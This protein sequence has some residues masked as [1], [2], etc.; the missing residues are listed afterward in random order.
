MLLGREPE[1]L[2]LDRLLADAREGRSGVLA[3]VGEAGIGKTALLDYAA[4]RAEGMLVLRARGVEPEAEIPFAGLAELLRPALPALDAIPPPQAAALAGALALAPPSAQDRFAVGAA[5]LS[6]VSAC[7]EQQPLL[8]LVDDA[9]LLDGSSAEALLFAA[10]RLLADPIALVLSVRE[11]ERSLV[12]GSDLRTLRLGGLARAEASQLLAALDVKGNVVDRLY[13][14]TAG[15]PLALIEL[16]SEADRVAELPAGGPVPISTSISAAFLRRYRQLSEATRR[17]LLLVAAGT[18]DDIAV[19]AR[20]AAAL[21]LELAGLDEAVE[22]ELVSVGGGRVEFRHPLARSAVYADAGAAERRDAHTALAAALPDRDV[23]RRAWHLAAAS[24]GPNAEAAAALAAAGARA[25][26]RSAYAAA[27]SVYEHA[28]RLCPAEDERARLVVAAAE[29]AWLAGD[30]DRTLRLLDE[31]S[32]PA[33]TYLRGQVAMSRGPVEE[34]YRL[35]V[36]AAEQADDSEEA[37]VRYAHAV[38]ACFYSGDAAAMKSAVQ[39]AVELAQEGASARATFLSQMALAVASVASGDGHAGIAAARRA[40]EILERSDE[41]NDDPWLLGWAALGPLWLREA[42]T[43]RNLLDRAFEEARTR[44][45]LG[46]LPGLLHLLARDQATTDAWLAAQ[47][48]YEEAIRLS[49]ETGQFVELAASV[50]GLAWLEARQ[51]R[52]RACRAHAAEARRRCAELG[53][54]LYAVWVEQALGDLELALGRPEEAIECYAAQRAQMDALGFAD[55]DISPAP[56]LVEAYLR[57][58]RRDDAAAEAEA[59]ERMATAKGQP[60]ALA[61]AARCRGLL[62]ADVELDAHFEAALEQHA[63]TPDV[64]ETARTQLA[65]GGRL[66]RARQRVRAREHLRVAYDAFDRLGAA[67]W[68]ETASAELAATGETARRR[69]ATTL[70]ELT[71]QELQIALLLAEG[72][73][74]REAAAA[75]FLSPKTVEYHLRHVYR[76]LGIRSREELAAAFS[77]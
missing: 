24:V 17:L 58:G 67:T 51:G 7:A 1:R 10:R 4:E 28:A 46:V 6:L 55:V 60:W 75:V 77:S 31:A 30:S 70:D 56:E 74:T 14:T 57:V 63:R 44:A 69:D 54:G 3:L 20:A 34:G 38:R 11:G 49:Q 40:V 39:R 25:A 50:A 33:A 52:E 72:K 45:A 5:T 15:N 9:H 29:A 18:S 48:S 73:T 27:A 64:F 65:Y 21:G 71:P 8:L 13:A 22:H 41:L 53:L 26:G 61:R 35:M 32:G 76:K 62:A 66:R 68:A 19:L 36:S 42:E 23:D 47:A 43:G 59:Y 16:A 12:D 2:A 37:V